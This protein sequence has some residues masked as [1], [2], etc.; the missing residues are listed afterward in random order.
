MLAG[1]PHSPTVTPVPGDGAEPGPP[2]RRHPRARAAHLLRPHAGEPEPAALRRHL[3]ACVALADEAGLCR[4][5]ALEAHA[6]V[7]ESCGEDLLR[8]DA[9]LAV[10][11]RALL[12]MSP[13]T[14]Q[15][16]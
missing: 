6:T 4:G 7:H 9:E 3:E 11:L 10:A 16:S 15:E 5:R 14:R 13:P 2:A 1:D 12:G 8:A